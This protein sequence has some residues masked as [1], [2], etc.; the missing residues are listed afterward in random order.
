MRRLAIFDPLR[1][2]CL[3]SAVVRA[4]STMA[5]PLRL[6]LA[7]ADSI[8]SG[9]VRAALRNK[10]KPITATVLDPTGN[11]SPRRR[12]S[13]DGHRITPCCLLSALCLRNLPAN[14][15]GC[16]YPQVVVQKRMD[17]CPPYAPVASRPPGAPSL[18]AISRP[19]RHDRPLPD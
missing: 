18:P 12:P 5:P 3:R 1:A 7:A 14:T 15:A 9:A 16:V 2:W 4:S 8:A 13:P 19:S 17:G 10:F 6:T 11:V